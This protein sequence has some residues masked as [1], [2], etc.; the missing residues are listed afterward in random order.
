M[1]STRVIDASVTDL[2]G[3]LKGE[4]IAARL[5]YPEVLRVQVRDLD[6]GNW[7][8]LTQDADWTPADPNRLLGLSLVRADLDE[9]TGGLRCSLS[10]GSVLEVVPAADAIAGDPPAW[11]LFSPDGVVLEF[12]P[13]LRWRFGRADE[14]TPA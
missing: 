12:G 2:L 14:L 3:S 6:G 9:G 1:G 13:G 4:I 5:T 8:L 7:R 10:D 11:E